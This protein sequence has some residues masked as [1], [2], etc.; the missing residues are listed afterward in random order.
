MLILVIMFTN[1]H[2]LWG[3][4]LFSVKTIVKQADVIG[5][6]MTVSTMHGDFYIN[7]S[8][9]WKTWGTK[10]AAKVD[11]IIK[12]SKKRGEYIIIQY[13]KKREILDINRLK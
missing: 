7:E 8:G 6:G 5:D 11:K 13:N 10:K 12:D 3:Q 2:L 4:N 1:T 9:A